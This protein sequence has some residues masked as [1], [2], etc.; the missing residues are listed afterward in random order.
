MDK[1]MNTV[2]FEACEDC[3]DRICIMDMVVKEALDGICIYFRKC[4][5]RY[6]F[7]ERGA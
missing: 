6:K 3:Y 4:A 5:E 2:S 1:L 7:L